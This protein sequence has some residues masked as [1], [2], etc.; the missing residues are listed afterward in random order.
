MR[1][2]A[3]EGWTD[4]NNVLGRRVVVLR[5]PCADLRLVLCA[6]LF[7]QSAAAA[8]G[9]RPAF[10]RSARDRFEAGPQSRAHDSLCCGGAGPFARRAVSS[11]RRLSRRRHGAG[12]GAGKSPAFSA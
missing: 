1:S 3:T 9:T 5:L 2:V 8:P 7:R 6:L 11:A 10:S 4:E 12:T